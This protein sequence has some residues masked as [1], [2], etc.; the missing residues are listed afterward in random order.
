MDLL[1]KLPSED[2]FLSEMLFNLP[3]ANSLVLIQNLKKEIN[4]TITGGFFLQEQLSP[5]KLSFMF[6]IQMQVSFR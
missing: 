5:K 4:K 3:S 6:V 1:S 2:T